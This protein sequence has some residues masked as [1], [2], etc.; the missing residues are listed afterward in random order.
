MLALLLAL[1]CGPKV[2]SGPPL[3]FADAALGGA[4]DCAIWDDPML[5]ARLDRVTDTVERDGHRVTLLENGDEAFQRRFDNAEDAELILV[6]SYIFTD[7][8]IG[9][10]VVALLEHKARQGATVIVQY[11]I[12]GSSAGLGE[13]WEGL[14]LGQDGSLLAHKPLLAGLPEAGVHLV[15]TNVPRSVGG[16]KSWD[17]ARSK[18]LE[19]NPGLLA[20]I[21][22]LRGFAHFDHEKYW[23]TGHRTDDGGLELRAILGGMN[24][25]SEYAYGGTDKVDEGSGRG[26]WRDTDMEVIGPV[27]TE[28]VER[29]LQLV[30]LN[31]V[32]LPDELDTSPWLEPQ[33]EVGEAT[34][35]FVWN[36]PSIG[37]RRRIEQA[38]KILVQHTP[39]GGIV[40]LE[41]AYFTPGT[42]MRR[43]LRRALRRD[44]RLAVLTNSTE[45]TDVEIV[46]Q[47]S[48]GVYAGLLRVDPRA[49]LYEWKPTPGLS[50]MH[51]KVASFGACGPAIVGS[52]NLDGQSS[53]RNSES[54]LI[55]RDAEFR[56]TFDEMYE[57]DISR[58][59]AHRVT[60]DQVKRM[61]LLA[62]MKNRTIY[63]LAWM[64]LSL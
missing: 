39:E 3:S 51:S 7:D 37:N 29:Y 52:A 24:I 47:A 17:R 32:T 42:S 9:R 58:A 57:R 53:E 16:F 34:V 10:E 14:Q 15:A 60:K 35:R 4:D 41:N 30:E 40:R 55:V 26:G 8:E 6:K 31:E 48:R 2:P 5:R 11:D 43:Q 49:A 19:A 56:R 18:G 54:V 38:Y 27:T 28:I 33:P 23:I 59:H 45:S 64:W 25:A 44:R 62:R 1:A 12:K 13:L 63:R 22:A 21:T 46:S 20:R 50:T 61:G 36:Q